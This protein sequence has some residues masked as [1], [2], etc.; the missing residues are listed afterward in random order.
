MLAAFNIYHSDRFAYCAKGAKSKNLHELSSE[1][2]LVKWT[3]RCPNRDFDVQKTKK[4]P[5][6]GGARDI[7]LYCIQRLLYEPR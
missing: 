5:A 2:V 1:E 6:R 3:T 4:S 7:H